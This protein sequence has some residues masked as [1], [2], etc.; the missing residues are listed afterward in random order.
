MIFFSLKSIPMVVR[1]ESENDPLAY[2]ESK[3][4]FPT[5]TN[6]N[7]A[8]SI[9]LGRNPSILVLPLS[10]IVKSLICISK[11]PCAMF[12]EVSLP[13]PSLELCFFPSV[14]LPLPCLPTLSF[15]PPFLLFKPTPFSNEGFYET[16]FR[17]VALSS[18]SFTLR[19]PL[20]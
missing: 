6:V 10:P 4:V 19:P 1:C 14:P 16:S 17:C 3:H 9:L 11:T 2:L 5:P 20:G 18:F 8:T 13:P 7:Y 12:A 15:Y